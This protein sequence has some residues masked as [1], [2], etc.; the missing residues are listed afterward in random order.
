M[1]SAAVNE[2]THRTAGFRVDVQHLPDNA[3]ARAPERCGELGEFVDP[4]GG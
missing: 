1:W 2:V 4:C 3:G